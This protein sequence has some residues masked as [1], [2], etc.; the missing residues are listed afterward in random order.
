VHANKKQWRAQITYGGKQHNLGYVGTKQE[1]ALVYDRAARGHT[2]WV[3][4]ALNYM[5]T[6][7]AAGVRAPRGIFAH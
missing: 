1:A 6:E 3:R 5:S 2:W 7:A 4:S